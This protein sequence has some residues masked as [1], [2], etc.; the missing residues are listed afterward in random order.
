MVKTVISVVGK[1]KV[2]KTTF[3][4]KLIPELKR[5]GYTVATVK[6]DRHDFDMDHP[7]KDTWR[8][9]MAGADVVAISSPQR[10]A[11]IRRVRAELS[12]DE[13]VALLPDVDIVLTEGYKRGDKPKIEVSRREKGREL[14]CQEGELLALVT[15]QPFSLDVPQFDLDDAVGVAD[16]LEERFLRPAPA[17]EET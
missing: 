9:T 13:V 8:H 11:M 5:R 12:L 6:H 3:L 4:E 1:S 17:L 10:M 15:D 16:L 2:G 14:L 7:G